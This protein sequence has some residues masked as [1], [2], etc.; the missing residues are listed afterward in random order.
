MTTATTTRNAN[1]PAGLALL[2]LFLTLAAALCVT[3]DASCV[4]PEQLH[5]ERTDAVYAYMNRT[6]GDFEQYLDAC[7]RYYT[8]DAALIIRGVGAY[9][10]KDVVIEYGYVLFEPMDGVLSVGM[11]MH[12]DP[13][14]LEWST[15]PEA[16]A[17]GDANDTV[18]FKVDYTF[19]I[20]QIPGTDTWAMSI[21]GLRNT[22]TLRF[23]HFGDRIVLDYSVNDPDILPLYLAGHQT[24]PDVICAKIFRRC[25]N[26]L[27]PYATVEE[28]VAFMEALDAS[29]DPTNACPYALSSNTTQCRDY[30]IDNAWADPDVHC[31]HTAVDSMTCMDTCKPACA[32]CP[33]NGHCAVT[34]P[35]LAADAAVYSCACDDGFVASAVDPV[36]GSALVCTPRTCQADWQCGSAPGSKCM[37]TLGRCGC[38][39]TFTWNATTGACDCSGGT[40][41]WDSGAPM[42]VPEGRCLERYHCTAQSWN[43]VQCR[44]TTPPNILSAF[45]SCLCNPGFVGGFENACTCPHGESAVAWSDALQG[46]VCLAPGECAAN[47]QC[48][49]GSQCAFAVPGDV[50]GVCTV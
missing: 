2:A 22:E 32:S 33:A 4:T 45:E 10:G 3:S 34:Y 11:R 30:H 36:T 20:S 47:W 17:A 5:A 42:C 50:I 21:G 19:L 44:A 25:T 28:C 39:P 48:P 7:E 40:V 37:S 38:A 12:P 49:Y 24:P 6:N 9:E 18:T 35:S 26:G 31:P 23:E 1:R 46:Q 29:V 27:N 15:S 41:R 8:E 43:R 14:T 13:V 16:V